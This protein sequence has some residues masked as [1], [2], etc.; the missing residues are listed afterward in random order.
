MQ[1]FP[2]KIH[3]QRLRHAQA[4]LEL[5][6]VQPLSQTQPSDRR[7]ESTRRARTEGKEIIFCKFCL[8]HILVKIHFDK[9]HFIVQFFEINKNK[10]EKES[11]FE[12]SQSLAFSKAF[13]FFSAKEKYFFCQKKCQ[14]GSQ[15]CT[16]MLSLKK[17][18]TL[19]LRIR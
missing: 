1:V 6:V 7:W 9:T 17:I 18:V 10:I 8:K 16:N 14:D 19:V 3:N 2:S 12:V 11:F 4:C 5:F 15:T 13:F